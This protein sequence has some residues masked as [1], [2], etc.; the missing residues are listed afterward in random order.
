M[1]TKNHTKNMTGLDRSTNIINDKNIN[2]ITC[3][4]CNNNIPKQLIANGLI[5]DLAVIVTNYLPPSCN[6]YY[7]ERYTQDRQ[8]QYL[9]DTCMVFNT[10]IECKTIKNGIWCKQCDDDNKEECGI[11]NKK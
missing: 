11:T 4:L 9:C 10:C 2:T 5:N 7:Y 6:K 3:E 8:F 1:A